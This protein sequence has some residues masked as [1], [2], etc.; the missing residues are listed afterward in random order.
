LQSNA[1]RK[2]TASEQPLGWIRLK[3]S[4]LMKND[5][6]SALSCPQNRT[7][8]RVSSYERLWFGKSI[9]GLI[10]SSSIHRRSDRDRNQPAVRVDHALQGSF[11]RCNNFAAELSQGFD[12]VIPSA[13][14]RADGTPAANC[15]H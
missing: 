5:A 10:G 13:L 7:A 9:T 3:A 12:A 1:S 14:D 4:S 6:S 2:P 8:R 15:T 11:G